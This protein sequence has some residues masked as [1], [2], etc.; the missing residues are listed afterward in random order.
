MYDSGVA[1]AGCSVWAAAVQAARMGLRV[2][3]LEE[4]DWIGG[5]MAAAAVTSMDES[6][7]L[8]RERGIYRQFHESMVAYYY[9]RDKCPF[10]AYFWGRQTQNQQEGGYEPAVVRRLLYGFI[11]DARERAASRSEERLVGKEWVSTCMSGWSPDH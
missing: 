3:L 8:I 2:L 6:G 4:T 11:Q 5:Q 7:P 1:G 10:V 9:G